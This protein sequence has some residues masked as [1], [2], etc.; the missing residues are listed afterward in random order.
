MRKELFGCFFVLL[1]ITVTWAGNLEPGAPPGPTMHSLDEIFEKLDI[2][3]YKIDPQTSPCEGAPVEKSG[4]TVA[5]EASDDGDLQRGVPWPIPRFTDHGNGTVTDNLTGLMWTK[6]AN[7]YSQR[8]FSYALSHCAA[9]A[10][11]GHTDWRLPQVKELQS[12][13]HY[14]YGNP[15]LP[16]TSG[17]GH[18]TDGN[19]FTNVQTDWYW[20][21]TH[22]VDDTDQHAWRVN[23]YIGNVEADFMINNAYVWP[24]RGGQ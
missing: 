6:N 2:I 22:Y 12:L 4:Q 1:F 5:Y 24:V 7:L 23:L 8:T 21:S 3:E 10:Q 20:S 13:I 14:G 9:C 15:A 11:G 16:D 17:T 18:W 19:P